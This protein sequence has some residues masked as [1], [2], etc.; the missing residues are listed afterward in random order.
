MTARTW[1]AAISVSALLA[2]L[3]VGGQARNQCEAGV[4]RGQNPAPSGPVQHPDAFAAAVAAQIGAGDFKA[5]LGRL[6]SEFA[7]VPA[8]VL[9][10][11]DPR[12]AAVARRLA[13]LRALIADRFGEGE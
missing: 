12:R 7:A 1:R 9:G 10:P 4:V 5:A 13:A 3:A 8:A 2:P 6:E 11:G